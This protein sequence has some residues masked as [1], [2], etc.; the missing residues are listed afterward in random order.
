VSNDD[1]A[2]VGFGGKARLG[3]TARILRGL[4]VQ[5]GVATESLNR[6]WFEKMTGQVI[7]GVQSWGGIQ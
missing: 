2:L 5:L 4:I 7:K 6:R 1:D 3:G